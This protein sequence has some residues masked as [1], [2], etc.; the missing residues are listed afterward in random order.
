MA[1][2]K[3]RAKA[4]DVVMIGIRR[5]IASA[6]LFNQQVADRVGL[7]ISDGQF[8][9]LLQQ[10]GSLTPGRLAQ[11]SGLSSGTVTG[12]LDRLERSGFVRRERDPND[13]RRVIVSLDEER[14]GREIAPH[15]AGQA[16]QLASVLEHYD[17]TELATI[18]DFLTRLVAA[19]EAR[20]H[21]EPDARA[22][23]DVAAPPP[24]GA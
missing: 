19:D 20:K 2:A 5:L 24:A 11:L 16:E 18:G 8:L 22:G 9:T 14:I 21:A 10:N 15:Y 7:G 6:I 1:K 4:A 17:V 13:R 23:R 12:V 3:K